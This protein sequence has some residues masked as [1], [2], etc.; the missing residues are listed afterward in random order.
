LGCTKLDSVVVALKPQFSVNAGPD[1]SIFAGDDAQIFATTSEPVV[2][3]LWTPPTALSSTNTV[4]TVARPATTT[5][6]T[7][8][9]I[10]P[11]GCTATDDVLVTIIPYCVKVKNAFTPN[12]DGRNDLW[13]VYDDY[14]CLKN[15]TVHVFNRYGS[16]VYESRDYRNSWN[17]TYNGK[18][19]PDGTYYAVLD[20]TL[21][22]G[23]V[24]T[25]KTDL[26][27]LR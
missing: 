21:I 24:V 11:L 27:V 16:K 22:T 17:G 18:P 19:I 1:I 20:F 5:L 12:G 8:S 23:R 26:T 7:L 2:S 9:A 3:A 4:T 10:N 14:G 25:V 13:Q 15:I 6:Y